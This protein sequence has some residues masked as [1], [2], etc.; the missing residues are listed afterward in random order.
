MKANEKRN[1][2]HKYPKNYMAVKDL[3]IERLSVLG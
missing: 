3:L 2:F 1:T